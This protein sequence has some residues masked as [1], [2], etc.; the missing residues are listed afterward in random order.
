MTDLVDYRGAVYL[1]ADYPWPSTSGGRVRVASI[2][3]VLQEL[4]PLTI[5]ALDSVEADGRWLAAIARH[6][7]RRASHPIRVVDLGLGIWHGRHVVL[8]RATSAGLPRAFGAVLREGE[9]EVGAFLDDAWG[10]LS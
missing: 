5:L 10:R 1:V 2:A 8:Q 3:T 9:G 4:G 7:G 6:R